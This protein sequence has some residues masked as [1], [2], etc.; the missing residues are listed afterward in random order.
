MSEL[1]RYELDFDL[2][3]G[4]MIPSQNGG[5]VL[6]DEAEAQIKDLTEDRDLWKLSESQCAE[7]NREMTGKM[8]TQTA[9]VNQLRHDAAT[10]S[11]EHEAIVADRDR[12]IKE[13]KSTID[14]QLA[15]IK[16]QN[17][18]LKW[19]D[20]AAKALGDVIDAYRL[21]GDHCEMEQA[22]AHASE[23]LDKLEGNDE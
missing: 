16:G 1:R 18:G 19:M 21:P 23:V 4:R 12:Q 15:K 20:E 13:L 22:I 3:A 10:R 8:L 5:W 14:R 9:T 6:A 17:A 11:I 2:S 7:D